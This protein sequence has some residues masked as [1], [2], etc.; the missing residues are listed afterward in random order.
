MKNYMKFDDWWVQFSNLTN[1]IE[2]QYHKCCKWEV[3]D[4]ELDAELSDDDDDEN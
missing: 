1:L 2:M 3:E 4:L